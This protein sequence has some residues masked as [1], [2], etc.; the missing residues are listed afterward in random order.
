MPMSSIGRS[1]L[2]GYQPLLAQL[3]RDQAVIE[4]WRLLTPK[5]ARCRIWGRRPKQQVAVGERKTRRTKR[6]YIQVTGQ[7]SFMTSF[8]PFTKPSA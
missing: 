8:A 6:I 1:L 4:H 2:T 5:I 7:S 3:A